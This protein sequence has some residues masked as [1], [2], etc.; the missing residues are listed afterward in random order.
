MP[1]GAVDVDGD[2]TEPGVR[3][4]GHR[5]L[6]ADE[7]MQEA[8]DSAAKTRFG[9]TGSVMVPN[10]IIKAI[11]YSSPA[12][13]AGLR[14]RE[15]RKKEK[16]IF[17][18]SFQPTP[19][20]PLPKV[21][22]MLY[23]VNDQSVPVDSVDAARAML[24]DQH[25]KVVFEISPLL[26]PSADELVKLLEPLAPAPVTATSSKRSSEDKAGGGAKLH[27]FFGEDVE[28]DLSDI[29]RTGHVTVKHVLSGG[30]KTL[31]KVCEGGGEMKNIFSALILLLPPPPFSDPGKNTLQC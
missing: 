23:S 10:I 2:S 8:F 31:L 30:G 6:L 1:P 21:G 25:G 11:S 5:M 29:I 24:S 27:D 7:S 13:H 26:Q 17:C 9:G 20:P 28:N 22:D 14:V 19:P 15:E 12:E 18:Q 16:K 3:S 4:P